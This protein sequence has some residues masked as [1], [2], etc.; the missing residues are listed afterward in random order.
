MTKRLSRPKLPTHNWIVALLMLTLGGCAN[1]EDTGPLPAEDAPAFSI[2]GEAAAPDR[3]W[4]AFED[5]S[6]NRQ[7]DRALD[8]NYSLAAAWQRLR[9]ARALAER[10]ASDLWPDLDGIAEAES[11]SDSED[12]DET[13][14]ALGLEASYEV[15]LWGRIQSRVE[16]E[17]F[18]AS[19]TRAD[20]DTAA[21]SLSAEVA[22][23]WFTLVEARAQLALVNDQLETNRTVLDLLESRFAAGQISSADVLRQ[24]QL[25][26]ATREE[27]VV[28]RSRIDVLEHLLVVLQG[29]PPQAATYDSGAALPDLPPLPDTGLPADLLTRRPD[30]RREYLTLQ[31]ADRDLASAVSDQYPRINLTASLTTAAEDPENLFEDWVASIAGQ[32]AAPLF[33]GGQRRAEV[34]RTDAVK[35]QRLAEYGRTVLGAFREVEDA[36]ARESRQLERIERLLAQLELARETSRQLGTQYLNGVTDYISVLSAIIEEQR[37][38]RESL[39]ARL[40]L[41]RFRVALYRA[42]AGDFETERDNEPA[43]PWET[44]RDE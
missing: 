27:A 17:R 37:L 20:Y 18:R 12:G 30:V 41:L 32:V 22:N 1:P 40:D 38:Q 33:D 8:E 3:W 34:E 4:T 44:T 28:V 31:A 21:L 35:R 5:P 10:E 36:L 7:I 6:L 24:R 2:S 43:P 11:T 13:R 16:A 29:R 39:T 23:A 14:F 42:L 25:V 9:A 26:E 15:D 19:A